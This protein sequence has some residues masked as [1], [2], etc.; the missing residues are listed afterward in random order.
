[1]LVVLCS[2][3]GFVL[4]CCYQIIKFLFIHRLNSNVQSVNK[5]CSYL[6]KSQRLSQ[7]M[8]ILTKTKQEQ[9]Q[10]Q[11]NLVKD[12]SPSTNI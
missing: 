5:H 6:S 10:E 11:E 2:F 3:V 9:E 4:L 12:Y 7:N 8:K 1:M